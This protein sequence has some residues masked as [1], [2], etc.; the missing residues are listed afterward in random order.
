LSAI[1]GSRK[2]RA[3]AL[4]AI[5]LSLSARRKFSIVGRSLLTIVVFSVLCFLT[6]EQSYRVYSVGMKAFDPWK[7]NSLSG[8]MDSGL[9]DMVDDPEIYYELKPNI[10]EYF[11]GVKLRTNSV[12]IADQEYPREKPED[13][14]RIAVVGSSWSMA[15]GVP[16]DKSYHAILEEQLKLNPDLKAVEF[17]NFSVEYYSLREI[18]A[19]TKQRVL[20]WDPDIILVAVTFTTASLVWDGILV[21]RELPPKNNPFFD[22][23]AL[24]ALASAVGL[25]L[26]ASMDT[27]RESL[28]PFGMNMLREQLTRSMREINAVARPRGIQ[29][30][31][32]WLAFEELQGLMLENL[33]VF[34]EESG[35]ILMRGDL[36]LLGTKAEQ[37]RLRISR[38]DRHPNEL[39]HQKIADV[40]EAALIENS[41]LP[42]K[43]SL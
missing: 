32:L 1:G 13:T 33:E 30:M 9:I 10:D 22:S 2:L 36:P 39:A 5:S 40:V 43:V 14:L 26:G 16:T 25:T 17:I 12:G 38:F 21:D 3:F 4:I 35:M 41:L 29:T 11:K 6:V 8:I 15:S 7:L 20:D 37:E 34:E 28:G 18:V 42:A 19:V 23:F 27:R 31:L 24:R